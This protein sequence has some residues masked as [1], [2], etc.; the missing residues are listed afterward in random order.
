MGRLFA[1]RK[2]ARGFTLIEVLVAVTVLAALSIVA[3]VSLNQMFMTQEIV[4]ERHERYRMVRMS[5]NRIATEISMA[6]MAGPDHGGEIVPGEESL[7]DDDEEYQQAIWRNRDPIQF[8]MIGQSDEIHFTAFGHVRTM[9]DEPASHHGQIGYFVERGFNEE[10]RPVSRL[11]RRSTPSFDSDLTRG[12]SVFMMLPE[13]ENFRIEYWDPGETEF[14]TS[15]EIAQGRWIREWDTTSR[16][17]A[18]R[19]PTRVRISVTLPAQGPRG[20][21]ETFVTQTTIS[22]SEVLEY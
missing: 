12:G 13:I 9:E 3:W 16:R 21:A 20:Q 8:G 14:G 15:R 10:G 2:K 4:T 7:Y 19:L 5:M 22:M 6:Y 1:A 18:G 17:F 11:M